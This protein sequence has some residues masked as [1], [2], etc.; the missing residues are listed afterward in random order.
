LAATPS[1][2]LASHDATLTELIS[3]AAW[4]ILVAFAEMELD[5]S[6]D[7][8]ASTSLT[9]LHETE[10]IESIADATLT[11]KIALHDTED[12]LSTFA[13]ASSIPPAPSAAKGDCENALIPNIFNYQ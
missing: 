4:A 5:A 7:A 6:I 12:K 11:I 2:F 1:I 8:E 3:A 9:R 13:A 10:E